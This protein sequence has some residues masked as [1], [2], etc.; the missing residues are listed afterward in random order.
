MQTKDLAQTNAKLLKQIVALK[1]G[2]KKLRSATKNL[3]TANDKQ[4]KSYTNT[5]A[6]LKK[7][8][9]KYAQSKAVMAEVTTGVKTLEQALTK[10]IRTLND[11]AR[12]T[13]KL[14]KLKGDLNIKNKDGKRALDEVNKKLD[15]N[16]KF[17]K[18]NSDAISKQ[19]LESGNYAGAL[20]RVIPGLAAFIMGLL[21]TT[22]AIGGTIL[23]LGSLKIAMIATGIGAFVVILGTVIAAMMRFTFFTD[24][25]KI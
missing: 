7:L 11:A 8:N 3:T 2:Q 16:S 4:L 10:E 17:V 18:K 24:S 13:R 12:N 19:R 14:T 23:A 9:Q 5:D 25:V 21:G 6:E 1:E 15:A 20:D 22:R